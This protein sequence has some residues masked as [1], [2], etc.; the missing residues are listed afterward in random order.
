LGVTWDGIIKFFKD[1][2]KAVKQFFID[3]WD[4]MLKAW[5]DGLKFLQDKWNE[6]IVWW[7]G[8][9]LGK[10]IAGLDK[11]LEKAKLLAKAL[12]QGEVQGPPTAEGAPP[13]RFAGGGWYVRGPGTGTSDSILARVSN[14]EYINRAAAVRKYG[15]GLFQALNSLRLPKDFIKGFAQGGQVSLR[16]MVPFSPLAF[17]RGGEVSTTSLRPLSVTIG[18]DTFDGMFAP[19]DVAEKFVRVATRRQVNSAGRRP[20]YWG[21][22]K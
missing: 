20:A 5:A 8:T 18:G 14:K 2:W 10:L 1:G 19:E 11:A 13:K 9:W 6:F 17:A 16:S 4:G 15:V 21:T 12:T 3:A 7:E 22:R